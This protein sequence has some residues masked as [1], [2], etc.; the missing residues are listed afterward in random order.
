MLGKRSGIQLQ[1]AIESRPD[2]LV[3][4]TSPLS[5]PVNVTGPVRVILYVSTSALSTD[6]I[7]LIEEYFSIPCSIFPLLLNPAVSIKFIFLSRYFTL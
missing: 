2:V 5:E 1:N 3:Y 7:V 6:F 4:T